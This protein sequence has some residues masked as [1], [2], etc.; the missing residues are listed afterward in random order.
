LATETLKAATSSVALTANDLEKSL[1]FYNGLGFTVK[2]RYETNGKLEGVMLSAGDAL[3]GLS[4]DDF[5]KGRDRVKG[6]GMSYYVETDQDVA[7]LARR[8]K[9]AGVKLNS[10]PAPMP[11][12]PMG[13]SATD[14]DGFKITICNRS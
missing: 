4:Q 9:D 7:D 3:L 5:S 1:R 8:A 10:E 14:P 11:W 12:G 13:F 6:I 2:D